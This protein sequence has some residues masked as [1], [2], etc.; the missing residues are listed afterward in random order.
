MIRASRKSTLLKA[1][2]ELS[3]SSAPVA[4]IAGSETAFA[5]AVIV[6]KPAIGC[7]TKPLEKRR[8]EM[9]GVHQ[10]GIALQ[11]SFRY[12]ATIIGVLK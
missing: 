10:T 2:N 5:W 12:S 7:N 4:D 9:G 3:D 6:V 8:E 11:R 1:G